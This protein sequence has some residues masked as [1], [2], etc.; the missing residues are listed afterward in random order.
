MILD[1]LYKKNNI[2]LMKCIQF[3]FI[4]AK[5]FTGNCYFFG[6]HLK[7][8]S[9]Q[10]KIKNCIDYLSAGIGLT[11]VRCNYNGSVSIKFVPRHR[12]TALFYHTIYWIYYLYISNMFTLR[13]IETKFTMFAEV[14]IFL[15]Q[16]VA[17]WRRIE[18]IVCVM[19]EL[20][21]E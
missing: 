17:K 6:V 4:Y 16:T 7:K 13:G 9:K 14:I 19:W 8:Q 3:F 2:W 12:S 5:P 10:I 21:S 18:K 11:D 1:R 15:I 20:A